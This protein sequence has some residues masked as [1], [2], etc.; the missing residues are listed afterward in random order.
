MIYINYNK[1]SMA[2]QFLEVNA[3]EY[4]N[5]SLYEFE[6]N[7]LFL[8]VEKGIIHEDSFDLSTASRISANTDREV[9]NFYSN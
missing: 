9:L 3:A 6:N 8:D 7:S 5:E 4:I 2:S 1:D